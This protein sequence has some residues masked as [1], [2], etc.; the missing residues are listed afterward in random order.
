MEPKN[1]EIYVLTGPP[2]VGKTTISEMLATKMQKSAL[3]QGDA[4]YL[5]VKNG[6]VA[7][8]DDDGTFMDLFW[9]N[10]IALTK[11]FNER[12]ISVILEYVIFPEQMS[13]FIEHFRR[14]NVLIKYV[15][16]LA[17][18]FTIRARDN[19]REEKQ[20]TGKRSIISLNE[21]YEKNINDRSIL[22]TSKLDKKEI[23]EK[24][25]TE[26]RFII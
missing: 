19:N 26:N 12:N 21:F 8:W 13:K 7:P 22:D 20:R 4:I 9:D 24:I 16:L 17:D 5:M 14:K 1:V 18:E 15:V 23:V 11:N 10:V 25:M 2:G 3:I 6:I